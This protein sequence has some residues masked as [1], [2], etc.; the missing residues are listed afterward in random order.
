MWRISVACV[1]ACLAIGGRPALA[2]DPGA[3]GPYAVGHTSFTVVDPSRD[4]TSPFGGRPIYISVWYPADARDVDG[5]RSAEYPLDP[6]YQRWP[7]SHS[8]D[9]EQGGMTP[10]YEQVLPSMRGPFPL[11]VASPGFG[12]RYF[13][14]LF[15]GLRLASHGFVVAAVQHYHDGSPYDIEPGDSIDTAMYNRPLDL[16]FAI[17]KLLERNNQ[18][19]D[20]LDYSMRPHQIAALGHSLGGYA[21]MVLAGGDDVACGSPEDPLQ[22]TCLP[23]RAAVPDGRIRAIVPLDGSSQ[24]LHFTELRRIDVPSM[25]VGEAWDQVGDWQARQHLGISGHP[26]YRADVLNSLHT[27]FALGC[28]VAPVLYSLKLITLAQRDRNL[29]TPQCTT[30][31]PQLEVNRLASKYAIAFLKTH[32]ARV[33]GYEHILTPGWALAREPDVEFFVTEKRSGRHVTDDWPDESYYFEHQPSC[34]HEHGRP[35]A[36]TPFGPWRPRG[37]ERMDR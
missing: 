33:R 13:A 14:L 12:G 20:V 9:W 4:A 25:A 18:P 27:S 36:P 10:A 15:Y 28:S 17:D 29:S 1:V 7:V 2:A 5:A 22:D 31:L 8:A 24:L 32:L 11:V 21:A 3:V 23:A 37:D 26:S 35:R 19:G 30:A 34:Q 6:F 16:S